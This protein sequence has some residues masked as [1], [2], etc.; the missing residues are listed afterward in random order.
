[1]LAWLLI[2]A[3]G[4]DSNIAAQALTD[5]RGIALAAGLASLLVVVLI[6]ASALQVRL[7]QHP[8]L[9][10]GHL[11]GG[12]HPDLAERP[13]GR[14]G[15]AAPAGRSAARPGRG[16]A[17]AARRTV[18]RVVVAAVALGLGLNWLLTGQP[19]PGAAAASSAA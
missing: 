12:P 18:A 14:A 2:P 16:H 7:A 19:G 13:A 10:A 8:G 5:R 4:A 1:M 3:E 9:A 6:I 17:A 15:G 11:R